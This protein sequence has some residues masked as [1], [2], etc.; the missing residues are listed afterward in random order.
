MKKHYSRLYKWEQKNFFESLDSSKIID[1]KTVWKISQPFFSRK[2]KT[3][4][5]ITL[6]N[7]NEDILSNDKVVADEINS[8]FKNATEF[9]EW[10]KISCK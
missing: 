2:W 6:V 5:K 10:M 7:E 4:D 3:V 9:L 8:F 1:N